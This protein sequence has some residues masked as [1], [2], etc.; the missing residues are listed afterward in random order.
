MKKGPAPKPVMERL[1]AKVTVDN[2]SGCRLWTGA[3]NGKGGYGVIYDG[4]R[5]TYTHRVAFEAANGPVESGL[6]IDHL[7]R[8]RA[9]CNPAHLRAVTQKVNLAC[10]NSPNFIAYREGKC[11]KGHSLKLRN[12]GSRRFCNECRNERRRR[13]YVASPA[14]ASL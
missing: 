7:C 14:S 9:C 4:T 1:L 5:M 6:V 13:A 3:T 11:S 10:G 12:D 2:E 8:N